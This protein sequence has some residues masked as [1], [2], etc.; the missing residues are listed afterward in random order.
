MNRRR[1]VLVLLLLLVPAAP[2]AV[3]PC[4]SIV[5][6]NKGSLFFGTNS[7]NRFAPG[8]LF[9]NKRGVRKSGCRGLGADSQGLGLLPTANVVGQGPSAPSPLR[10]FFL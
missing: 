6:P 1:S 7:D 5:F 2:A 3:F 9:I 10:K 4:S 8:Q